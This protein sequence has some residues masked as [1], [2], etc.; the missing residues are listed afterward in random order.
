VDERSVL[1]ALGDS[2]QKCQR[3]GF[4]DVLGVR[5][6]ARGREHEKEDKGDAIESHSTDGIAIGSPRMCSRR[7]LPEMV[8]D[9][10]NQACCRVNLVDSGADLRAPEPALFAVPRDISQ[11]RP[12][13][14]AP[15]L[16]FK[17]VRW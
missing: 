2:H 9:S 3:Q 11:P 7:S 15:H 5:E 13:K 14:V 1:E 17:F 8:P 12:V 10:R 6:Q 16:T 4:E